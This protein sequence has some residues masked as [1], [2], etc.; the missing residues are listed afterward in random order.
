M[1]DQT[2][3]YIRYLIKLNTMPSYTTASTDSEF[4]SLVEKE[5]KEK[6]YDSGHGKGMDRL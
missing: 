3:L 1:T 6:Q 5:E 4:H 2:K